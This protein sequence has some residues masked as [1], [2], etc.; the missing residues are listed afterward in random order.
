MISGVETPAVET[1]KT[2]GLDQE[3]GD[4]DATAVDRFE[5]A[6]NAETPV[7]EK[8]PSAIN[9]VDDSILDGVREFKEGFDSQVANLSESFQSKMPDMGKILELQLNMANILIQ[10]EVVTKAGGQLT[11]SADSLLKSQ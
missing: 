4:A 9:K 2:Q 6:M 11:Q 10:A 5:N 1:F 7:P 3:L 8:I